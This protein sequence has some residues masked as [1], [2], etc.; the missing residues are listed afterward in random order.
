MQ[1]QAAAASSSTTQQGYS[2]EQLAFLERKKREASPA[3]RDASPARAASS[4]DGGLS[5]EQQ[6]FLERKA[7]EVGAATG[8]QLVCITSPPMLGGQA[9][10]HEDGSCV[11]CAPIASNL[12]ILVSPQGLAH[13]LHFLPARPP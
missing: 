5:P 11:C 4:N 3:A 1:A 6:A 10:L 12:V 9:Q 8:R 13:Y 2:P 7:A